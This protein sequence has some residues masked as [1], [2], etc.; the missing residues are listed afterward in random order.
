[1][2]NKENY[3]PWSSRLLWYAK[4][5]PN[6]K[7]IHNSIINGPYVRRM[8]PEPGDTNHKVPVNK[9]FHVQTDDE[10]TEK[11]LK[12]IKA[13][14]QAIQTILLRE[15]GQVI[16]RM[17][18][19]KDLHIADYTQLYDFLKYNQ[20]EVDELKAKQL[21]KTQDP[22]A[23]MANSNNPYA[24]LAP[25]QDQPSF[26]QNYMQQPMPNPKDII[27]PITAM[28]MALTLMAKAF[29]LNYSTPTNN[30]QRISSNPRNRQI[31]QPGMNM[32]QDRQMQMVRGNANQNGNGNLVA[33]H[34][35]GNAASH[36]Y[37]L[38]KALYG[39]KQAPRAWYDELSMFLLQNHFF[40]GTIDPTL[41]T[42]RFQDEILV[43]SG[44]EL[45]GF[46]DADYVRCKDTFKS[47]SSGA[48]FLGEKLVSW[49]SKKQDCTALSTA[50]AEYVSLS[51]CCTQV[52]WMRT[53]LTD[54]G[55]HFNKIPIY[56]DSKSAIAISCN[57]VQHSRTKHIAV[58]YYFIMEHV[59]KG[60]IELY[61][62]K[63]DYQLADLFTKALPADRFNYL[64]HRL[65]MRSLS[66]Q[67]L[68]RLA[69]SHQ[70][71]MDLPRNTP[72][73]RVEVLV[74]I[75]MEL[76][77]EQ[78]QQGSGHEV[79]V[80]TEGVEELKRIVKIKGEKKEALYTTLG[81]N[82]DGQLEHYYG[83]IYQDRGKSRK[84]FNW[85]T[86]KYGK[87]CIP[88]D[89][90]RY[91]KDGR[92]HKN[93][94]EVKRLET[95]FCRQVNQVHTLDFKGLTL[96]M[97]HDLAERVRMVYTGDDDLEIFVSHAWRRLFEIQAPLVQ[98][99]ILE[100]FSTC[101]ISGL[102]TAEEMAED[103]FDAYWLERK[104]VIPDNEDL[105]AQYLFRHAK[106]RK[107][108]A[109]LLG[110]CF[111]RRLA[112][113]FGLV[114]DDGLRGLSIVVR[115]L[116]LIDMGELV[117]LN[118]CMEVGD[119]RAWVAQGAE[120]QPFIAAAAQGG[121]EDAPDVY[122]GAQAVPTPIHAHPPPPATV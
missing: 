109:R 79:S 47:T 50:E 87:I 11:E 32:G 69:K 70:S 30:N 49:S 23:L 77:L 108:G 7:I 63:T 119:D 68:D 57:L 5:K 33:A 16:Q 89:P 14:D 48:Q 93:V 80:S 8:I 83:R 18:K 121:A 54:Y 95:I 82:K 120:R 74:P 71:R 26:N 72:L 113:H 102:H 91:Y 78:S 86:A 94:A 118:I 101:R 13:D 53:Q 24:F 12:Q 65:G 67:E 34:A 10:L 88:F 25:H 36:V 84:V 106:E 44:F 75:E 29:K 51:A 20:K 38:K 46:S 58:R 100:F 60:T 19:T 92:L 103:G 117:R 85:E 112:H 35:E 37:K 111:I 62:V 41:F 42:R 43:D 3:M 76:V 4:S 22:L 66:P 99:F 116:A 39:L 6:G 1:M 21:A 97:R 28:N 52:L 81:R 40:K 105:S 122:E 27:D 73:D 64:V 114:S 110:G 55:F 2:L 56:Y 107:S 115:E 61:F 9:T 90:K 17:G 98:E 96:D 45:T 104:K 15:K 59:E 31:A